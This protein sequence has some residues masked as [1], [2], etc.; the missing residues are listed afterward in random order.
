MLFVDN[1]IHGDLHCKNWKV[2]YNEDTKNPQ[3]IIYDCGIC[4]KN[5]YPGLTHKFWLS[6]INYDIETLIILL[7][8]FIKNSNDKTVNFDDVNFSNKFDAGIRLILKDIIKKSMGTSIVMNSLLNFFRK[9]NII[10][11]KFL[12]NFTILVCVIEEYMKSNNLIDKNINRNISMFDVI[13]DCQ[14]DIIA[15]CDVKKCYPKLKNI[16]EIQMKDNFNTYKNNSETNNL[17]Y[18]EN[19]NKCKKL[20][21]S[22]SLS[23]L[24]FKPPA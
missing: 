1:F 17:E 10:I 14:L 5:I 4:F 6:L 12:L 24:T 20:F 13:N 21:S 15:F 9:N 11:H 7:K 23:K 22:I 2:R 8:E 16:F 18:N 3:M 19:E